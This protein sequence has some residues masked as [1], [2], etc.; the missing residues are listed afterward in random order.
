M[1]NYLPLNGIK[2]CDIAQ[3]IAGPYA[4]MLLAQYGA[5]VVKIEPDSGDWVR[6][7][8]GRIHGDQSAQSLST[9]RGKRSVVLDLKSQEGKAA[10]LKLAS[11]ADIVTQSFRPG[12]IERLGLD[13]ESV[14]SVNPNVIY[15]SI[16][17]FGPV[18]PLSKR[19]AT[20][21]ILQAFTGLQSITRDKDGSPMRVG[22]AIID[23]ITGLY[24]YQAVATALIARDKGMGGRKLDISLM[25]SAMAVQAGQFVRH[26]AQ[27]G[28]PPANGVP[29]GTFETTTGFINLSA[30]RPDHF[31]KVCD[32]LGLSELKSRPEFST[33]SDRIW[34]ATEI[35]AL[36][37]P[38]LK[39]KSAEHWVNFFAELGLMCAPVHEYGDVLANEHVKTAGTFSWPDQP[40]LGPIPVPQ[41]PGI[42]RLEDNDPRGLSPDVGQ[43]TDEIILGLK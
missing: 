18:G 38:T 42:A 33:H 40:G 21:A 10:A 6:N 43:H 8:G 29:V 5:D 27:G 12:V 1:S 20:D 30:N 39:T 22:M 37:A 2:V 36:L 34:R 35:N 15:L 41:P 32:A 3:G 17:G 31:E 7:M 26:H 13:Y 4:A 9:N 28:Q 11:E 25:E 24:A 14:K 23:Y 16:S 19:P